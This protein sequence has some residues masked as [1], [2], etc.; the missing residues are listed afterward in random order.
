MEVDTREAG[1]TQAVETPEELARG[2]L[3][4]EP[5]ALITDVDGTIS[6]IAEDPNSAVVEPSVV[7]LLDDLG[8]RL[9]LVA[10]LSGRSVNQLRRLVSAKDLVYVGNHGLEWSRAGQTYL[11]SGVE[12]YQGLTAAVLRQLRHELTIPGVIVED[13]GVSGAIHFRRCSDPA[14]ARNAI[15]A[16]TAKAARVY[17]FEVSEGRKVVNIMPPVA[18][19]KGTAV[20]RLVRDHG[21][22]GVV[23]LGD[24][25]T[26]LDAFR[27]LRKMA[28]GDRCRVFLVGVCAQDSPDELGLEADLC[29]STVAEVI[30]FLRKLAHL[31]ASGEKA[32][33]PGNAK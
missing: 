26:D 18:V 15:L 20:E 1:S 29:V 14:R 17:G 5:A 11:A 13:K 19:N 25:S 22:R 16:A 12:G 33:I 7:D 28:K 21:L 8:R 30:A 32:M 27:S 3:S 6:H 24:D 4:C 10:L 31:I 2:A 9:A 23:Y